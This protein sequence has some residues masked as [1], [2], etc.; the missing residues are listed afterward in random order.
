LVEGTYLQWVNFK[1]L[2]LSPE[3]QERFMREEAQFFTDEGYIFGEEG[4][5]YGR[6]NLAAPTRV[7][8]DT[9]NRLGEALYMIYR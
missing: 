6:I 4:E 2:G 9:L 7:I 1:A 8:E 3:E 5:G